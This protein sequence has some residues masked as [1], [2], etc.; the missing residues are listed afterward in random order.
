MER[1]PNPIAAREIRR[2]GIG[3]VDDLLVYGPAH[4]TW[5]NQPRYVVMAEDLYQEWLDNLHEAFVVRV[6]ESLEDVRA[7]RVYSFNRTEE[8]MEAI[9]TFE[10]DEP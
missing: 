5:R 7:G 1:Q 6:Q 4:V 8:M 10:D 9:R 2:R 3:A